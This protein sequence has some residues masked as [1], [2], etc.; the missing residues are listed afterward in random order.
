MTPD[1]V[2]QPVGMQGFRMALQRINSSVS[3]SD[4]KRHLGYMQECGSV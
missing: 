2:D 4:V 1:D 3:A